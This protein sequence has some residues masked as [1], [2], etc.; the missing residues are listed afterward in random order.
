VFAVLR[1]ASSTTYG[2]F[3]TFRR[4]RKGERK[5]KKPGAWEGNLSITIEAVR[6]LN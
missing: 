4:R 2:A 5:G 6:T 1:E 3:Y